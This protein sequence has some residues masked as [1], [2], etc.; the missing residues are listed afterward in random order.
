MSSKQSG[1]RW[2]VIFFPPSSPSTNIIAYFQSLLN[3]SNARRSFNPSL[4]LVR[5]KRRRCYQSLL[6]VSLTVIA[7]NSPLIL[8]SVLM[9]EVGN[10]QMLRLEHMYPLATLIC[11]QQSHWVWW[12]IVN[13][14]DYEQLNTWDAGIIIIIIKKPLY[15]GW[16]V[17]SHFLKKIW[18]CSAS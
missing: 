16:S 10:N 5:D 8:M 2:G 11:W 9:S 12:Q 4:V 18:Q 6:S 7:F 17:F 1:T 13:A 15:L 14:T 3:G